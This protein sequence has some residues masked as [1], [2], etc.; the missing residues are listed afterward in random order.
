MPRSSNSGGEDVADGGVV[1]EAVVGLGSAEDDEVREGGRED[2]AAVELGDGVDDVG[3]D[4]A[5]GHAQD[6]GA[7]GDAGELEDALVVLGVDPARDERFHVVHDSVFREIE[8]PHPRPELALHAQPAAP[9]LAEPRRT[10]DARRL[11]R[12]VL[13]SLRAVQPLSQELVVL[14]QSSRVVARVRVRDLLLLVLGVPRHAQQ[15]LELR[16]PPR[17]AL[18][19]LALRAGPLGAFCGAGPLH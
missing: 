10:A 1:V 7:R 11:L 18:P 8:P 13:P 14:D 9:R 6:R 5:G 2:A 16:R 15:V 3:V 19:G 4:D 12:E 17:P